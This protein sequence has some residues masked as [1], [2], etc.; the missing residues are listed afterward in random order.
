MNPVYFENIN[1]GT[2]RLNLQDCVLYYQETED[3]N[4][5]NHIL[6]IILYKLKP[7]IYTFLYR[8]TNFPDKAE[9]LAVIEDKILECLISYDSKKGV[10]FTT[11]L[12]TCLHNAMINLVTSSENNHFNLSFDFKYE[13]EHEESYSLYSTIG[14]EDDSYNKIESNLLLDSIKN[15]LDSSEYKVCCIIINNEHK[16]SFKD[17]AIEAGLT[18]AAIPY[19]LKRLQKKFIKYNITENFINSL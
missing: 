11:F 1:S 5:R 15:K 10:L 2:D 12:S 9:L 17:I 8:K 14:K 6:K 19:I 4:K 16:L 18:I 13:E 7:C 3:N